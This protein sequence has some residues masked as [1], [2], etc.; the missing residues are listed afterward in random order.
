[1][2]AADIWRHL[3]IPPTTDPAALRLAY[4]ARLKQVRPDT[5]P[6]GFRAL[7]EAF[8]AAR[9][10]TADGPGGR[11]SPPNR[12]P[13]LAQP[14]RAQTAHAPP[15]EPDLAQSIR[16]Q[17][18]KGGIMKAARLWNQGVASGELSFEEEPRLQQ[19]IAQALVAAPV[20]DIAML[21]EAARLMD[22]EQ[23]ARALGAP[24]AIVD[25]MARRAALVWLETLRSAASAGWRWRESERT[26]NRAARLLLRPAPGRLRTWFPYV[27]LP[28][29]FAYW[30]QDLARYRRSLG[31][32]LDPDRLAW[33]V[34]SRR[35]LDARLATQLFAL[36]MA[37]LM[38]VV[39]LSVFVVL[40]SVVV[41][42][43]ISAS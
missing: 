43:V 39:G 22:W 3:G 1:M 26:R 38:L 42:V 15:P 40:V 27:L 5:D 31:D 16:R 23:A 32:A 12:P 10:L 19:E 24:T 29:N 7:R 30:D 11:A 9:R 37:I 8:E 14:T 21:N 34:A 36:A 41:A 25:V 2:T 6:A 28:T 35:R 33:C 17:L 13:N 4:A 20:A 18:R